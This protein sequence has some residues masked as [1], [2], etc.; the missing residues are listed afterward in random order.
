MIQYYN[1]LSTLINYYL[2]ISLTTKEITFNFIT[3][4]D[5]DDW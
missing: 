1:H 4:D 5:D 2:E 3:S